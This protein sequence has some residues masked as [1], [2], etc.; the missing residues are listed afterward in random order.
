MRV[1]VKLSFTGLCIGACLTVLRF[2]GQGW[3]GFAWRLPFSPWLWWLLA[4]AILAVICYFTLSALL[5]RLF[6]RLAG[7]LEEILRATRNQAAGTGVVLGLLAAAMICLPLHL[8]GMIGFFLILC[9]E[10][11]CGLVGFRAAKGFKNRLFTGGQPAAEPAGRPKILDTS[12]IID[13]RILDILLTGFIEGNILI[14]S[15]VLEEL[16]HIADS[17]DG[18]KRKRG[19]RG[20]DILNE[21]QNQLQTPVEMVNYN[22]HPELEVDSR[23][24]AMAEDYGAFVVTNDYNL[25]K[26]AE[27]RRVPVLNINE[28]TNAIKSVALPGEDISVSIVKEGKEPGQGVGYLPDGTM[29]V[30]ESGAQLLGQTLQ[31]VVTSVLQTAAGR[32]IFSKRKDLDP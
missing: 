26:V 27:F 5:T 30:V 13:G 14:P 2:A 8:S 16:R 22:A 9:L 19:R 6:Y 21:I 18:L 20:L 32:M 24:L 7:H 29:I 28:L 31:V 10:L 15:F 11:F 23:L 1:L 12:V 3:L 25:N 4:L 17:A